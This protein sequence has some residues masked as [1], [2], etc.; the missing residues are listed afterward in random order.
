MLVAYIK[1]DI[2][3]IK[4]TAYED[5]GVPPLPIESYK[6]A[7]QIMGRAIHDEP[8]VEWEIVGTGPYGVVERARRR[9]E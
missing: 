8:D 6:M 9:D 7:L 3:E 4:D 5:T 1:R 2:F